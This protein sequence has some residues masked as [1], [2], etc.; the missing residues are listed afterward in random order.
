[1]KKKTLGKLIKDLD[2]I[3]S[4]YIRLRDAIRTTNGHT[5]VKC[6]TCGVSK[7]V[8]EVDAGHFISRSKRS[9]RFDEHNVHAQCKKCNMPPGNGEQYLYSK[10][11]IKLYGEDELNRL[12][13]LKNNLRKYSR[14][15]VEE[16]IRDYK[17][18]VN[19]MIKE[20]GS[21]WK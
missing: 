10:E 12:I 8:I 4:R 20:Y 18:R 2:R 15:E 9:I 13:S 17:N 5:Y 19:S 16:M 1:M 21:P 11:I 14:P 3:F 6:I 7:K